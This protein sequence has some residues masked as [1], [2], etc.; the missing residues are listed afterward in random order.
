MD[1]S[2]NPRQHYVGFYHAMVMVTLDKNYLVYIRIRSIPVGQTSERQGDGGRT[3]HVKEIVIEL[4]L[5]ST[6]VQQVTDMILIGIF[7][8]FVVEDYV[9]VMKMKTQ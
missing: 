4:G 9:A 5:K 7:F 8:V 6:C 1:N 3:P 2:P